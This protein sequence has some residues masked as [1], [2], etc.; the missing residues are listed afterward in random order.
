[1]ER[2]ASLGHSITESMFAFV[3][4]LL[5]RVCLRAGRMF[6]FQYNVFHLSACRY[7]KACVFEISERNCAFTREED[8]CAFET[9]DA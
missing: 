6:L 9:Q 3:C 1:M 5:V 7:S 2:A 8:V 4:Q